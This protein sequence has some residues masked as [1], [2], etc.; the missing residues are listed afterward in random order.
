MKY[1]R[2]VRWSSGGG[3]IKLELLGEDQEVHRLEVSSECAAALVAALAAESEKFNVEGNVQQFIRPTGMQTGKTEQGEPLILV[4]LP[5]GAELPLV[6]PAE[7]LGVLISEL[8]KLKSA[9][10]PGSQLRW[11]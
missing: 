6:F 7:S 1:V 10:Q 9:I 2:V 11:H 4:T 5:S 3:D 8:E